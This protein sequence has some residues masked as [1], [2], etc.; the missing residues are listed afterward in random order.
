MTR[1]QISPLAA[2]L[3]KEAK[4]IEKKVQKS[5]QND[6]KI[7]IN[8]EDAYKD[9]NKRATSGMISLECVVNNKNGWPS[10]DDSIHLNGTIG[11]KRHLKRGKKEDEAY[12]EDVQV[13][14]W[15][16]GSKSIKLNGCSVGEFLT[17]LF[18]YFAIKAGNLSVLLDNAA[19]EQGLY[20]YSKA[21]FIKSKSE[22]AQYG[23]DNEMIIYLTGKKKN[24]DAG[25]LWRERYHKLRTKIKSKIDKYDRCKMFWKK[26]PPLLSIPQPIPLLLRGGMKNKEKH[27]TKKKQQKNQKRQTKKKR[28]ITHIRH[29]KTLRRKKKHGVGGHVGHLH[30]GR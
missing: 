6:L 17:H 14:D 20:I 9:Q 19:G 18:I 11:I 27:Q 1:K 13:G 5:L 26:T 24:K 30:F 12:L 7:K 2:A 4:I 10:E 21:G 23:E 15:F 3:K 29:S 8:I 22:R 25:D 16:K 28:C